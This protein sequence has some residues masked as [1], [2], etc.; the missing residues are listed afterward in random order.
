MNAITQL[1]SALIDEAASTYEELLQEK[2]AISIFGLGYV[3]AVSIGCLS[4]LG[5]RVVGV[6]LAEDKIAAIQNGTSPMLE[7]N[8]DQLL[9]QGVDM[10]I[11]TAGS[12]GHRAV[13]ETD[14]TFVS[15]GTPTAE[16]GSCDLSF[17]RSV[18]RTIG[19]ALREKDEYH[20][21]VMRCSVPPGTTLKVMQPEI[22]Q[23]SGKKLGPDFGL[24]F[25]PEFLREGTAVAD[26]FTPTKTVIGANDERAGEMLAEVYRAVEEEIL[27][28]S[29]D[30]AEMV[31]YVDNTWHATKVTFANEV[32]RLCKALGTDSHE[33]MDI[34]VKD[35]YLNLSSYY[36]KPGFAFGGSCLPKE[37]RAMEHL[38]DELNISL[39]LMENLNRS[40]EEHVEE[41]FRMIVESKAQRIGFL[42]ITF[43]GNTDDLRES[44][45]LE[46]IAMC[47]SA[48]LEVVLHDENLRLDASLSQHYGYMKHARP[49]LRRVVQDLPNIA[50]KSIGEVTEEAEL[51]V[52]SHNKDPYRGAA[53]ERLEETK[54]LDLVRMSQELPAHKNYQGIGW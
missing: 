22:E 43:K 15:V 38:A 9:T 31:K 19:E 26:F 4:S 50:R 1:P 54:V 34:F 35:R 14:I 29:I 18:S 16:D 30:A 39:P 33:V 25:N 51:V 27:F 36:L 23:A 21:I 7:A 20:L 46:L 49:H 17:V 37:V 32:G 45:T 28:C 10:G 52:I 6:D 40:N 42:G 13:L 12:N 8:L 47:Q 41:A 3:G 53:Y 2:T 11:I 5:H 44:P 24:C 48:G